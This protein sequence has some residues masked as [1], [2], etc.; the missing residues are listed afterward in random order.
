MARVTQKV[1]GFENDAVVFEAII[2]TADNLVGNLFGLRAVSTSG[3][4]AYGELFRTDGT[5]KQANTCLPGTDTTTTWSLSGSQRVPVTWNAAKQRWTGFRGNFLGPQVTPA[6]RAG[7]APFVD[8]V[9]ASYPE[10]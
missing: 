7:A 1:A 9:R 4:Q 6:G 3:T 5:R 8:T 2:D 10:D